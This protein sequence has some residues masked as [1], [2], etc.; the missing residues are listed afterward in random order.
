MQRRR[1]IDAMNS[2]I[3]LRRI[4]HLVLLGEELHFYR[5]AERANLSQPAFSRSIQSLESDLGLRLFDRASR[6]VVMTAAG[7]QIIAKARELMLCAD[8]LVEEADRIAGAEGGT[9]SFGSGLMS[10]SINLPYVLSKL[11]VSSPKLLINVEVN[12]WNLL[13]THLE[14]G[15]LEFAIVRV[16][17]DP[18]FI[19]RYSII[20]LVPQPAS[21]FCRH[22]HPL[23]KKPGPISREQILS[24]PWSSAY[25]DNAHL[26]AGLGLSDNVELPWTLTC[27]RLSLL[28]Q[29]ALEG[30]SLLLTWS[31]WL[32]DDLNNGELV[33]IAPY[34]HP[35]IPREHLYIREAIV[36]P[37]EKT[38]SPV[39]KKA[40]SLILESSNKNFLSEDAPS[41]D[42]SKTSHQED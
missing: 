11:R 31:A 26:K 20:P 22:D 6:S 15:I 12:Y 17:N 4:R 35:P 37:S 19:N 39:A 24:Y 33:D 14:Q 34:V 32:S 9:L 8:R 16:Q 40:I 2:Q 3:D 7:Q 27:R 29:S 30:D 10:A 38:L 41:N 42:A 23:V 21:I 25:R 18:D 1:V 5:A 28:K 36:F 13:L